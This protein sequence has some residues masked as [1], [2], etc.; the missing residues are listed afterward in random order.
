MGFSSLL[1]WW[2]TLKFCWASSLSI[3]VSG[4][5]RIIQVFWTHFYSLKTHGFVTD[6]FLFC[7]NLKNSHFSESKKNYFQK[8]N[9]IKWKAEDGVNK[10]LNSYLD[11]FCRQIMLKKLYKATEQLVLIQC[12]ENTEKLKQPP[13]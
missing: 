9:K 2:S 1:G 7:K 11:Y 8:I 13:Q 5:Y 4:Q 12:C 3:T 6:F 10:K